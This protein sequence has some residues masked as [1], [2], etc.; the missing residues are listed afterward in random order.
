MA[1]QKLHLHHLS[2]SDKS[3]IYYHN[4][5]EYPLTASELIKWK[6]TSGIKL[7]RDLFFSNSSGFYFLKNKENLIKKRFQKEKISEKKIRI[8]IKASKIIKKIPTIL[9]VGLTGSCA[10]KN[11]T[12]KSDIDLIIIVKKDTLWITRPFVYLL[13]EIFGFPFRRSFSKNLKD[14]LCLNIWLDTKNLR[15][16]TKNIFTAHEIA[17]IKPLVNHQKT[18]QKFLNKNKWILDFWPNA[19]KIPRKLK[20]TK[21]SSKIE[22]LLIHKFIE[23]LAFKAQY[24]Y[25]KPKITREVITKNRAIFHPINW[26]KKV[27]NYLNQ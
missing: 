14:R 15:W 23:N 22:N 2:R 26:S 4:L 16:K 10:M 18:H 27:E 19:V 8:A 6:V 21:N 9:F 11:A 1:S 7:K 5:F 17:Q 3:S 25:M 12:S 20:F 24:L 13:L